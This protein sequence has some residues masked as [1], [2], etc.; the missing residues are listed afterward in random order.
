MKVLFD[1]QAFSM[2]RY[3]GISRCFIELYKH[4][5]EE[6]QAEFAL[7]ECNNA[8]IR[9]ENLA[10]DINTDLERWILPFIWKYKE[11]MFNT[12]QQLKGYNRYVYWDKTKYNQIES[13]RLLNKGDFDIFHPTFF[14]DYFVQFLNGK[15]FVLTIH[16]MI[17]ELYPQYFDSEKDGQIIGKRKLA[18]LASAIIA[19]SEKTKED[20]IRI[21]GVPEE[22]VHVVYHG[23][24][25]PIAEHE[26]LLYDFPYILYVGD[27][28]AYKNF[29]L[30]VQ[31]VAKNL[32]R[33]P[34]LKIVCT[35]RAFN[36]D[37]LAMFDR[38]GLSDRF[39]QHWVKTDDE[40]YTLYH[41]A[42][43]FVYSSEYEGFGIPIL[44]AYKADCPV[45]LNHASCFPEIAGDAAI[46]FTLKRDES[47]L[48][49]V[50]EDFL[51]MDDAQI[52]SLKQRQRERLNLYSW[53]KSALQL[54]KVYESVLA[55]S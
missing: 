42:A 1:H 38:L 52:E 34:K 18:P 29:V 6:I 35:G 50:M 30:F 46:Y 49:E 36:E 8:Y 13:I 9:E 5:P 27:R 21:L 7:R 39:I 24:S 32:V 23:C 43:C 41:H 19:V 15:P 10:A 11:T 40:F 48:A 4:F 25:F 22:K 12:Y 45:L 53:E 55:K 16:D 33:H 26:H 20:V 54:A 28:I 31:E 14:D 17:P 51:A 37:E 44:E 2:Q 3:G 47:N